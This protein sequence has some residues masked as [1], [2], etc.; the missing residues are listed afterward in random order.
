MH[1]TPC[2]FAATLTLAAS[3]VSS[4]Q[5][6]HAAE[7]GKV[8]VTAQLESA[9]T[10][11]KIPDD[12]IG[13]GYETSAVAQPDFFSATNSRMIRLY[14]NLSRHGMIRIG[15][16][17]SDHTRFVRDG[18]AAART[19]KEV[20]IINR[21]SLDGLGDFA[22]ATGWQVMWGLN[23]GTGSR[24]EAVE[25]ATAVDQALGANLQS[26][27]IGNEVDL[28]RKYTRDYD[29][30]HAAYLDYKAI[31]RTR[32]PRATFSGPDVAGNLSFVEKFVATEWS[33]MKLATL[34][35]YRGGQRD[36]KS[37]MEKLLAGDEKFDARLQQ[38]H[39]LAESHHIGYRINEVNSYYGGGKEGVSDTFAS[40][41]WCLDYLFRLAAHGCSGVNLQTD[42]NQHGFVSFY[43]PIAHDAAG[44]CS[45][46]PEYYGMLAFAMAGNGEL[47]RVTLGKN[48][49]NVTA[50]ATRDA[51]GTTC[52]TLINKDLTRD[53][54]IECPLPGGC[55]IVQA[56]RLCAP[57]VDARTGVTFAG[58]A[59]TEDGS[60]TPGASEAIAVNAGK[61]RTDL[62]HTSA[63]VLK[64]T[65]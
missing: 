20:T 28:M 44:V 38:L 33:D 64:F 55:R 12:F 40:S 41:L 57:S 48:D 11:G 15:G 25:E 3:I 31:I 58:S 27:E 59:V 65:P 47:I 35:Y 4:F 52:L 21:P 26:F 9:V 37:T 63:V 16:N 49:L 18:A 54:T 14:T 30:Y 29:A 39:N 1:Q 10:L 46:R 42:I 56:Y 62:P 7:P 45:A 13:F 61:C 23:L 43:S 50:Y 51:R 17:I 36:P 2:R 5:R 24:E 6:I 53:I 34:H 8:V 32:L 22:R 19:E 60:W